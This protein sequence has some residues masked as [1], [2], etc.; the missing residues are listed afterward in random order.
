MMPSQAK[1]GLPRGHV[2]SCFYFFSH[3]NIVQQR[4]KSL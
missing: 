2:L 3:K 1:H 4:E